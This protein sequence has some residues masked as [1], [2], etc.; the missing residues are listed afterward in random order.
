MIEINQSVLENFKI[1]DIYKDNYIKIYKI[2][3]F[4]YEYFSR[5]IASVTKK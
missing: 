4:D 3:N 5:T 2:Y 1:E